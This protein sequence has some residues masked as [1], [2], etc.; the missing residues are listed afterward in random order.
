MPNNAAKNSLPTTILVAAVLIA[1]LFT[2]ASAAPQKALR[3]R[4]AEKLIQEYAGEETSADRRGEI[5]TLLRSAN[6]KLL[7]SALTKTLK[8][9]TTRAS[10]LDLVAELPV[11][12]MFKALK[13]YVSGSTELQAVNAILVSGGK[14]SEEFLLSKWSK[15]KPDSAT[16]ETIETAFRQHYLSPKSVAELRKVQMNK[17]TDAARSTKIPAILIFQLGLDGELAKTL[18]EKWKEH[19][20]KF[21]AMNRSFPLQG[22]NLLARDWST[23]FGEEEAAGEGDEEQVKRVRRHRGGKYLIENLGVLQLKGVTWKSGTIRL[24]VMVIDGDG[25]TVGV[26]MKGNAMVGPRYSKGT[27]LLTESI[28]TGDVPGAPLEWAEITFKLSGSNLVAM[29]GGKQIGATNQ[30]GSQI[31]G[32]YLT[33]GRGKLMLGSAEFFE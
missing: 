13:K 1:G 14:G 19:F 27:W 3:A 33:S 7:T 15:A 9:G 10:S 6:H 17:R 31:N 22:E 2:L 12:N 26:M 18:D 16:F 30:Y 11:P 23:G 5:V 24:R 32:L 29:M 4:D 8:V 28:R 25:A 21:E 20:K